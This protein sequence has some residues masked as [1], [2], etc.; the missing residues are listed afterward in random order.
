MRSKTL[1]IGAALAALGATAVMPT[2]AQAGERNFARSG[3]TDVT[4]GA[5]HMRVRGDA[6]RHGH[7]DG[8]GGMRRGHYYAPLVWH[9]VWHHHRYHYERERFHHGEERHWRGDRDDWRRVP[10]GGRLHIHYQL[11]TW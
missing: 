10:D 1:M 7:R 3:A 8:Y 9:Q 4:R 2:L 6:H 11:R 5:G